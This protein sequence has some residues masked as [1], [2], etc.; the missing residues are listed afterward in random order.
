MG[1]KERRRRSLG[2]VY[3]TEGE[4]EELIKKIQDYV[5]WEIGLLVMKKQIEERKIEPVQR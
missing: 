1:N 2:K 3:V 5:K 4:A